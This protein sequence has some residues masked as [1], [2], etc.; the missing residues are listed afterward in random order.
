MNWVIMMSD[1]MPITMTKELSINDT[2]CD[3]EGWGD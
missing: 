3:I 1:D 2:K